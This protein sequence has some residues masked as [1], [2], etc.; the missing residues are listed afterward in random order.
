[1]STARERLI[2]LAAL[3]FSALAMATSLE[4]GR[5]AI[6]S[7]LSGLTAYGT[8]VVLAA[9]GLSVGIGKIL[10]ASKAM[11]T[12]AVIIAVVLYGMGRALWSVVA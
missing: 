3:V 6:E 2:A 11:L 8:V 4:I 12:A 1:M 7:A 9:L 5:N 10:K